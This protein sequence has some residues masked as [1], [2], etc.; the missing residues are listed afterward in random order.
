[1][2][3]VT[4]VVAD[5]EEELDG[6]GDADGEALPDALGVGLPGTGVGLTEAQPARASAVMTRTVASRRLMRTPPAAC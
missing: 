6:V 2:S 5:G 4:G 1:M 3:Q